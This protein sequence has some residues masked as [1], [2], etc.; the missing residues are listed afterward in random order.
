MIQGHYTWY[1]LSEIGKISV[2]RYFHA[3]AQTMETLLFVYLGLAFWAYEHEWDIFLIGITLGLIAVA[4]FLSVFGLTLF[5][6][7]CRGRPISCREQFIL[8]W[9]GLRG[10]IAFA[11]AVELSNII[12]EMTEDD[13]NGMY[14]D[15][16]GGQW[17]TT[18]LVTVVITTFVAGAFTE[19]LL[20]C[21]DL[22]DVEDKAEGVVEQK[23][24]RGR[25]MLKTNDWLK[26]VLC[27]EF[28][29]GELRVDKSAMRVDRLLKRRESRVDVLLDTIQH[30]KRYNILLSQRSER[31]RRRRAGSDQDHAKGPYSAQSDLLTSMP[32]DEH[33]DDDVHYRVQ[34]SFKPT[35]AMLN[36]GRSPVIPAHIAALAE[37]SLRSNRSLGYI[38]EDEMSKPNDS[39]DMKA[40]L[41]G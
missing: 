5:I 27:R 11:L 38:V 26:S 17:V 22:A 4:R 37:S 20:E 3:V 35:L 8:W 14:I 13:E 39:G 24:R 6:N 16:H 28:D 23:S 33:M 1:N 2:H 41:L 31:Y 9:G 12:A 36:S 40:S 30:I 34:G 29:P 7:P 32:D 21:L 10:G 15:K 25:A 19:T 18:T